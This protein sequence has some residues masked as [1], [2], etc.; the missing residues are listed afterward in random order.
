MDE[1]RGD[2]LTIEVQLPKGP[3]AYCSEQIN[4]KPPKGSYH[5]RKTYNVTIE[6]GAQGKLVRRPKAPCDRQR[7]QDVFAAMAADAEAAQ[8]QGEE[9]E[10]RATDISGNSPQ[11][12]DPISDAQS[13]RKG[14]Y[15]KVSFREKRAP[16]FGKAKL[17]PALVNQR[18]IPEWQESS[19]HYDHML[20]TRKRIQRRLVAPTLAVAVRLQPRRPPSPQ[21]TWLPHINTGEVKNQCS[22]GPVLCNDYYSPPTDAFQF[23]DES[24]EA[25]SRWVGENTFACPKRPQAQMAIARTPGHHKVG[26][27]GPEVEKEIQQKRVKG[28]KNNENLQYRYEKRLE[29]F[30][31]D[32]DRRGPISNFA[33]FELV[34]EEKKKNHKPVVIEKVVEPENGL[35]SLKER[36]SMG[37]GRFRRENPAIGDE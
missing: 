12:Q 25:K 34:Q 6:P 37:F 11:P 26:P 15:A 22:R 14:Y 28:V 19:S 5:V 27:A 29:A 3:A 7:D 13:K 23:R 18:L 35:G 8:Q 36:M 32:Q 4:G 24:E 2:E 16:A 10:Q 21:S 9:D 17:F 33:K 31:D 20:S 1:L 30:K